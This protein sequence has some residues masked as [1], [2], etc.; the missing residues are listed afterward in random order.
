MILILI[1]KYITQLFYCDDVEILVLWHVFRS[2]LYIIINRYQVNIAVFFTSRL[3]SR[4]LEVWKF[5]LV[6][7]RVWHSPYNGAEANPSWNLVRNA[8]LHANICPLNTKATRSN[9]KSR[10]SRDK[11]EHARSREKA[12]SMMEGDGIAER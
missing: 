8:A 11:L 1:T 9:I 6:F 4:S 10:N 12:T 5:Q 2:C 3:R 7:Y